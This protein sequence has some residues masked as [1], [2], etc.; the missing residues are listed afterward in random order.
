MACDIRI[1]TAQQS[2]S[3]CIVCQVSV[4]SR[5]KDLEMPVSVWDHNFCSITHEKSKLQKE[6]GLAVSAEVMAKEVQKGHC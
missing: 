2:G 1:F 5:L 4:F 6:T 3:S